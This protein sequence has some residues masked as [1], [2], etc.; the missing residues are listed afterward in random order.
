MNFRETSTKAWRQFVAFLICSI[1]ALPVW[2]ER[3]TYT[4]RQIKQKFN[5]VA[6]GGENICKLGTDPVSGKPA[7]VFAG[8]EGYVTI[9]G[10]QN[11]NYVQ[12]ITLE[13]SSS[14]DGSE[15]MSQAVLI[16][17][18]EINGNSYYNELNVKA[19]CFYPSG[20]YDYVA[21][22][23]SG[24]LYIYFY[25]G[26]STTFYLTSLSVDCAEQRNI[27]FDPA[28]VTIKQGEKV[29]LPDMVGDTEGVISDSTSYSIDNP[30]IAAFNC[31]EGNR[32]M[33]LGENNA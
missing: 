10:T 7:L 16:E 20:S 2:A 25:K 31:A 13:G 19:A 26:S 18:V 30:A 14:A 5:I 27:S 22:T 4:P 28:T 33:I 9:T 1:V 6:D 11:Y 3:I 29:E 8:F 15:T 12:S 32:S 24:S 23:T 21:N 17:R